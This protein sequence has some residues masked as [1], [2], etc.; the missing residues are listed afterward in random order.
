MAAGKAKHAAKKKLAADGHIAHDRTQE[1]SRLEEVYKAEVVADREEEHV[2]EETI[3]VDK[4]A[5][6]KNK[7][8]AKARLDVDTHRAHHRTQEALRVNQVYDTEVNAN[9]AE[10]HADQVD[11]HVD[12]MADGA[13][14]D[15]AHAEL[16][17]E[18]HR[19]DTKT[20]KAEH[21]D[22][23]Y[24]EEV[25]A[26]REQEHLEK[27]ALEQQMLQRRAKLSVSDQKV[28]DSMPDGLEKNRFLQYMVQ[29]D[30]GED[31]SPTSPIRRVERTAEE[32]RKS[33]QNDRSERDKQ[34]AEEAYFKEQEEARM[35][36]EKAS[37]EAQRQQIEAKEKQEQVE[38]DDKRRHQQEV[39]QEEE[40]QRRTKKLDQIEADR[41][42]EEL[43]QHQRDEE[44]RLLREARRVEEARL[45]AKRDR[46]REEERKERKRL[47]EEQAATEAHAREVS[48]A[49]AEEAR[50]E[51]EGIERE[52]ALRLQEEEEERERQ[53]REAAVKRDK[54]KPLP[55][56]PEIDS[57]PV[58]EQAAANLARREENLHREEAQR[59]ELEA[60]QA[61]GTIDLAGKGRRGGGRGR[62]LGPSP[63]AGEG[64]RRRKEEQEGYGLHS[65][66]M[67]VDGDSTHPAPHAA[68]QYPPLGGASLSPSSEASPSP[69]RDGLPQR[70]T[71]APQDPDT[72]LSNPMTSPSVSLSPGRVAEHPPR[73]ADVPI[74]RPFDGPAVGQERS[75]S[76]MEM[77]GDRSLNE[78]LGSCEGLIKAMT[79]GMEVPVGESLWESKPL[80][81][82]SI[83]THHPSSATAAAAAT[84]RVRNRPP[85]S[86]EKNEST[87]THEE[88]AE[89]GQFATCHP[90]LDVFVPLRDGEAN[91]GANL[92][93][94]EVSAAILHPCHP[95]TPWNAHFYDTGATEVVFQ[96]LDLREQHGAMQ[97]KDEIPQDRRALHGHPMECCDPAQE[98]GMS[99]EEL[100]DQSRI[101]PEARDGL[102]S[103]FFQEP[104]PP[105]PP[106]RRGRRE[107]W[108]S[109]IR[110]KDPW[111]WQELRG[112]QY[113]VYEFSSSEEEDHDISAPLSPFPT[114]EA[115]DWNVTE[116]NSNHVHPPSK[117]ENKPPETTLR[118]EMQ[119]YVAE[120]QLRSGGHIR[121]NVLPG[122][123]GA[124][125]DLGSSQGTR[126][127]QGAPLARVDPDTMGSALLN[128][129]DMLYDTTANQIVYQEQGKIT[130]HPNPHHRGQALAGRG[131]V[132]RAHTFR[133]PK[134]ES[135]LAAAAR[136]MLQNASPEKPVV[137]PAD[138]QGTPPPPATTAGVSLPEPCL[139][140]EERGEVPAMSFLSNRIPRPPLPE[141]STPFPAKDGS[142]IYDFSTNRFILGE[143]TL[144]AARTPQTEPPVPSPQTLPMSSVL[145]EN[146]NMS[147]AHKLSK[148]F[149]AEEAR[150][151][152]ATGSPQGTTSGYR[153]GFMGRNETNPFEHG[154]TKMS[155]HGLQ[156]VIHAAHRAVRKEHAGT[157]YGPQATGWQNHDPLYPPPSLG[158]DGAGKDVS[159]ELMQNWMRLKLGERESDAHQLRPGIGIR[160]F[161][162]ERMAAFGAY[163]T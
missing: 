80:H 128:N 102:V 119:R 3:E 132:A 159:Q 87:T 163:S 86:A 137:M 23:V 140:P 58:S 14:K 90:P 97:S 111:D 40:Q 22:H 82:P 123:W 34:C 20:K 19:A 134:M 104:P 41:L 147:M 50:C 66:G 125:E 21:I 74:S 156:E 145:A 139:S 32:K 9:H 151:Q 56:P 10:E 6:G 45:Q 93:L 153:D 85:S 35:K 116:R 5:D 155:Q 70:Y 29:D 120:E 18:Q 144:N 31:T 76:P 94:P 161:A 77:V 127:L 107:A 24:E 51:K 150:R 121:R 126:G 64:E 89:G 99:I 135:P 62:D 95:A 136:V 92:R 118:P 83:G 103:L 36:E 60:S 81:P 55:S 2:D 8:A 28:F 69:R 16:E 44:D 130:V 26:H 54:K 124:S 105:P 122:P 108:E 63:P 133:A 42:A 143:G 73:P 117:R 152:P 115:F 98:Q 109:G 84:G 59:R 52:A 106:P 79:Q 7:Q 47:Q 100:L 154:L 65:R 37:R 148:S 13:A 27:E 4:M 30:S 17:A 142:D 25:A 96:E 160:D 78:L 15:K 11:C 46:E 149:M 131:G 101:P 129:A 146:K 39:E 38:R 71:D 57:P 1:A 12:A 68:H 138:G 88:Y 33:K 141:V 158:G 157:H 110:V 48:Y 67:D 49:K 53:E 61:Q 112:S 43:L 91:K 113:P 162:S 114:T 72:S 75:A